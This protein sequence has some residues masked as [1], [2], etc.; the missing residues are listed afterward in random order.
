MFEVLLSVLISGVVVGPQPVQDDTR[1]TVHFSGPLALDEVSAFLEAFPEFET[2]YIRSMGGSEHAGALLAE[3]IL[4]NQARVI[5]EEY[6]LSACALYPLVAASSVRLGE[7]A[8]VGVHPGAAST[9]AATA[10]LPV[11]GEQRTQMQSIGDWAARFYRAAG[12]NPRIFL[13]ALPAHGII[14]VVSDDPQ[15]DWGVSLRGSFWLWVPDEAYWRL[16][17]VD[18]SGALPVSVVEAEERVALYFQYVPRFAFGGMFPEDAA[19]YDF[20]S[21]RFCDG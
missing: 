13:D 14:C 16:I 6:C 12:K 9:M 18:F 17:G 5:V 21:L 11:A 2:I 15:S 20:S 3:A 10:H 8:L 7:N 1:S 19:L 4:A